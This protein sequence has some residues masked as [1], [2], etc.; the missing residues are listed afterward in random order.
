MG[1]LMSFKMRAPFKYFITIFKLTSIYFDLHFKSII[2]NTIHT[3][4]TIDI[5]IVDMALILT[6]I[7]VISIAVVNNL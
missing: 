2:V 5:I 1:Y 4:N 3:L 6:I 7:V